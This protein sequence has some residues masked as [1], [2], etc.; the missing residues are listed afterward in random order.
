MSLDGAIN[1]TIDSW[2]CVIAGILEIA[3]VGYYGYALYQASEKRKNATRSDQLIHGTTT[4]AVLFSLLYIYATNF[5]F[6]GASSLD[7][8]KM[9]IVISFPFY[10]FAKVMTYVTF[11]LR[12]HIVHSGSNYVISTNWLIAG[13]CIVGIFYFL[14]QLYVFNIVFNGSSDGSSGSGSGRA[15]T[16]K[17]NGS[18]KCDFEP[19]AFFNPLLGTFEILTNIVFG[20]LFIN[21]IQL[22]N[23]S[24]SAKNDINK[25]ILSAGLKAAICVSVLVLSTLFANALVAGVVAENFAPMLCLRELTITALCLMLMTN[26]YDDGSN[27]LKTKYIKTTTTKISKIKL[28]NIISNTGIATPLRCRLSGKLNGANLV[29][30]PRLHFFALLKHLFFPLHILN[31]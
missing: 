27:I 20:Y 10:G 24:I 18:T 1:V 22:S 31:M 7:T 21:S 16:F 15:V 5:S 8:C 3:S 17:K 2:S 9:G 12:L 19:N 4:L 6:F 13:V 25:R 23:K 14:V 30:Y 11:A 29:L 28:G 26:Y